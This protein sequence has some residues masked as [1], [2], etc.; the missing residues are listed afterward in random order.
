MNRLHNNK[1]AGMLIIKISS[2]I[3]STL[4]TMILARIFSPDLYGYIPYITSLVSMIV[5]VSD[6][7]VSASTAYNIS[8]CEKKKDRIEFIN[9]GIIIK[10]L[11]FFIFTI[12]FYISISFLKH[13][14]SDILLYRLLL[15]VPL[16]VISL[17]FAKYFQKT[18]EAFLLPGI[19]NV[20]FPVAL[21]VEKIIILITI[22][23]S[24]NLIVYYSVHTIFTI[25][26]SLLIYMY[27]NIKQNVSF[28]SLRYFNKTIIKKIIRYGLSIFISSISFYIYMQS[29]ILMIQY[30]LDI[31]SLSYYS[32]VSKVSSLIIFPVVTLSAVYVP[33]IIQL[34]NKKYITRALNTSIS[35]Y[36]VIIAM[37][38]YI[39][40]ALTVFAP[41]VIRV[42]F[43]EEYLPG[44]T[45]LRIYFPFLFLYCVMTFSSVYLDYLGKARVRSYV[46]FFTAIV[47]I[48]LNFYLIPYLGIEGAAIT[49]QLT[50]FPYAMFTFILISKYLGR[51][52]Y[53]VLLKWIVPLLALILIIVIPTLCIVISIDSLIIRLVIYILSTIL[54]MSLLLLTKILPTKIV[55]KVLISGEIEGE[56][57]YE[58][59]V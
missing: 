53:V 3:I 41:D 22:L 42:L 45:S 27:L 51:E 59:S 16:L 48:V 55:K 12:L 20:Y 23:I 46:A 35:V 39:S 17:G 29:D 6:F 34:N 8:L 14:F 18:S 28:T 52:F 11:I 56:V 19:S 38:L 1:M 2:I 15:I 13:L 7:G 33:K 54:Y 31:E 30:Y 24:T 4:T 36:K 32:V 25:V 50:Y 9:A 5:L 47:N 44:V 26:V 40:I 21:T 43:G 10:L 37:F 49:T 58:S 57:K